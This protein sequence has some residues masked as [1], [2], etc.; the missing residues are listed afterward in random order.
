MRSV[1][2]ALLAFAAGLQGT[3]DAPE[4]LERKKSGVVS[5]K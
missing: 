1:S 5:G 2:E 3:V 4:D